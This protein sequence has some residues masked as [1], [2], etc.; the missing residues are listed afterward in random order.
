MATRRHQRTWWVFCTLENEVST[1]A[2]RLAPDMVFCGFHGFHMVSHGF[3]MICN[4]LTNDIMLALY[5]FKF[6]PMTFVEICRNIPSDDAN[7]WLPQ[8]HLSPA[9]RK[10][11][12][13]QNHTGILSFAVIW[14]SM[15]FNV[16]WKH[17]ETIGN[18]LNDLTWFNCAIPTVRKRTTGL[19]SCDGPRLLWWCSVLGPRRILTIF[20]HKSSIEGHQGAVKRTDHW[21]HDPKGE[22]GRKPTATYCN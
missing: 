21:V 15:W 13:N 20:S 7:C 12:R 1:P 11:M 6:F 17:V 18:L 8:T 14:S 19:W 3:A 9:L 5:F 22:K 4:D 2:R 16:V 10:H